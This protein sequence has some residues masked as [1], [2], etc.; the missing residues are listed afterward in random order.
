MHKND[1]E[2]STEIRTIRSILHCYETFI[3][4]HSVYLFSVSESVRHITSSF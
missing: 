3:N 2:Q 4:F 1:K